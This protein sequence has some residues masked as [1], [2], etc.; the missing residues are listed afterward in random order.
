MTQTESTAVSQ[1][2]KKIARY[3][4]WFKIFLWLGIIGAVNLGTKGKIGVGNFGI[5]D[6]VLFYTIGFILGAQITSV[7][8]VIV[9]LILDFSLIYFVVA[10]ILHGKV[11]KLKNANIR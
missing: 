8:A 5:V 3:Q 6:L 1:N 2:D 11:K 10:Y 4:L 9:D 7:V